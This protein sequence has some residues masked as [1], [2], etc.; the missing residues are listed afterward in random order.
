MGCPR[1]RWGGLLEDWDGFVGEEDGEEV[2]A[3]RLDLA[4]KFEEDFDAFRGGG[5]FLDGAYHALERAVCDFHFI[6]DGEVGG[7]GD[8]LLI[9][10]GLLVNLL[11]EGGDESFRD[12]RDFRAEADES[13]NALAEGDCALH[14]LEVEFGEDVAGEERFEPPDFPTAGGFAI[15]DA[16][17]EDFDTFQFTEVLGSDVFALGLGANAEPFR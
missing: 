15:F 3:D 8:E 5:D 12:V 7:D 1:N 9:V 2:E 11:D 14:V 13:A 6:A 16:R 17:A 4:E 10:A